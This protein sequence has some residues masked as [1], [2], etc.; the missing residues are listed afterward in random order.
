MQDLSPTVV[1]RWHAF[2]IRAGIFLNLNGTPV[3]VCSLPVRMEPG[4]CKNGRAVIPTTQQRR[5][6]ENSATLD[7]IAALPPAP[8]SSQLTLLD[9]LDAPTPESSRA[10]S[11]LAEQG[12]CKVNW[13]QMEAPPLLQENFPPDWQV[14]TVDV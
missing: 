5:L 13:R 1:V 14:L 12:L 3:F 9:A 2:A 7:A 6:N 4:W 11:S 10:P 8:A